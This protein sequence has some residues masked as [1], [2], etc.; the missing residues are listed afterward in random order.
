MKKISFVIP[1][2]NS[3]HTIGHVVAE[4]DQAFGGSQRYE[5]E[6]ILVNDASPRDDTLG[7]ISRLARENPR[8]TAV[9]LSKNFG[10]DSALMAGYSI[11]TGD[12]VVSLDDDGQ[13]PPEEAW[14]LLDKL[15]EGWDVVF[16]RYHQKKHSW[17]K[18]L[19][20]RVNDWMACLLLDKPRD[21]R[22]CSYFAMDRFVV[23]QMK[24]D[25][26]SFPYIWGLILRTTHRITNVYI[27]HRAR[28]EGKSNF[29]LMKCLKVWMNGFI[30]FSV[31]PLRFSS[32]IGTLVALAGFLYGI[33][34]V[35]RQ[36]IWGEPVEGWSSLIVAILVIGGLILMMLGLL[37]EYIGRMN[38]N[39]N[40]T[41]Q[42]II[43]TV[44]PGCRPVAGTG[45]EIKEAGREI[46]K[47][48]QEIKEAGRGIK[49][50]DGEQH[51]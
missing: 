41:P 31:K 38:I 26:N 39:L 8:V 5:Y 21:L 10:Q 9:D 23:E 45:Q 40:N 44:D 33:A 34:A 35:V 22:L 14:K 13:N 30:A 19:G 51:A 20:S 16:G 50:E 17:I 1:C 12:Y 24:Q 2:Y 43:R 18:N 27:A 28:E 46:E 11:S 7:A 15:E 47:A 25:R 48:G 3:E 36:V 4:I 49:K 6:I 37:G 42:Y 29:T 32:L